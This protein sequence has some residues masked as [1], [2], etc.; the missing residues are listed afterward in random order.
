[1]ITSDL[2]VKDHHANAYGFCTSAKDSANCD[3]VYDC[4][5]PTSIVDSVGEPE[6]S[7]WHVTEVYAAMSKRY[8]MLAVIDIFANEFDRVARSDLLV[9]ITASINSL[10]RFEL[11]LVYPGWIRAHAVFRKQS[12]GIRPPLPL[13]GHW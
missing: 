3:F 11:E 6:V 12:Q 7:F 4:K 5:E 8:G 1:M 13:S 10:R 9:N 2:T